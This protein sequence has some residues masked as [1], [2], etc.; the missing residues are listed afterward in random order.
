MAKGRYHAKYHNIGSK[1]GRTSNCMLVFRC[2]IKEIALF[3]KVKLFHD[4]ED[5]KKAS[6]DKPSKSN[7]FLII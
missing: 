2:T 4:Y 1:T 6:V 5:P 7:L 3:C